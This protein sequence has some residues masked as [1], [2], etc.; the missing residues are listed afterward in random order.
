LLSRY[1]LE[2]NPHSTRIFC[3]WGRVEAEAGNLVKSRKLFEEA[4]KREPSNPLIWRSY[5][6]CESKYGES[7]RAEIVFQRSIEAALISDNRVML[8]EPQSGDFA[9]TGLWTTEQDLKVSIE[10]RKKRTLREGDEATAR[11]QR[12][13]SERPVRV[14]PNQQQGGWE[15]SEW[16]DQDEEDDEFKDE[17]EDEA[18]EFSVD[19]I[20][21]RAPRT[22][23]D[24]GLTD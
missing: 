14:I 24:L 15:T 1:G 3:A 22:R 4:V 21:F 8:G 12:T 18:E 9:S 7:S 10:K 11:G 20:D 16:T 17:D 6:S 19:L 2:A 5:E 13:L 23:L